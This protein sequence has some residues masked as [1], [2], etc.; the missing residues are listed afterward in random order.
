MSRYVPF[1]FLPVLFLIVLAGCDLAEDTFETQVVVEGFFVS[2]EMMPAIRLSETAPVE[3]AYFFED[4]ALSGAEVSVTLFG[5]PGGPDIRYPLIEHPDF[6]GN[7]VVSVTE[8][9]PRVLPGRRYRLEARL[10]GRPDLVAAG[11]AVSAETV[12]PGT[13][14]VVRPPPDTVAYNI[15]TPGPA[16]DVTAPATDGGQAVFVFS[17]S[18]LDPDNNDL[19]PTLADLIESTDAERGDFVNSASPLLNE[20][21]YDRNAD[22]TLTI[23]VPWFAIA[24]YGPN[25]FVV[26]SLDTALYDFLRSRDAQFNPTTLS[27]GEIQRAISNIENGVGVFGSLARVSVEA[28][29]AE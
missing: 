10:A 29:I 12:T 23:R 18:S 1:L 11:E 16:I 28:F 3:E 8:P 5:E 25:Q 26:N 19:T 15:F 17:I 20:D 13:F 14:R 2:G 21:N 22:G 4:L 24:F 9:A 27:P 7:Y 6:P